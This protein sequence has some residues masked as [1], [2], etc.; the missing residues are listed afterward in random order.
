MI[1]LKNIRIAVNPFNESIDIIR[2]GKNK[3]F[4]LDK[5]NADDDLAFL[6]ASLVEE[7]GSWT[8]TYDL[9]DKE[10][11]KSYSVKVNEIIE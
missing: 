3:Q 5:R 2:V 4:V 1:D 6:F 8:W 9:E 11:K 10:G 7:T